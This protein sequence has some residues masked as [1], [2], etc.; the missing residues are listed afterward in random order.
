MNM[1]PMLRLAVSQFPVT[2]DIA[3][4]ALYITQHMRKAADGVVDIF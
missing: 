3:A 2:G 4:N 1:T